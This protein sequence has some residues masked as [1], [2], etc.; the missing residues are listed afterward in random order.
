MLPNRFTATLAMLVMTAVAFSGCG[1][2][3]GGGSTPTTGTSGTGGTNST[4][5]PTGTA[6]PV[7]P[8][9]A[10]PTCAVNYQPNA[11][12]TESCTFTV[13]KN[14]TTLSFRLWANSTSQ[15]YVVGNEVAGTSTVSP[16]VKFAA[17]SP[18]TDKV[19]W[20][21]SELPAPPGI[22]NAGPANIKAPGAKTTPNKM[23]S[24][25]F[26]TAGLRG[27]NLKLEIVV[28]GS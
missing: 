25:T 18:S 12:P 19:E 9:V 23:G 8:G 26:S 5:G 6:N 13:D 22:C 14:W 28:L 2:D 3:S 1:G 20:T 10:K 11:N 24:W 16:L 27:T 4:G 7:A 21:S 17:P 15:C